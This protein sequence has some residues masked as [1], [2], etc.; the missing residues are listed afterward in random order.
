MLR[1]INKRLFSKI[2]NKFEIG[3]HMIPHPNK[4]ATGGEDAYTV[5]PDKRLIAMADGVGGWAEAGIDSGVFS[6]NLCKNI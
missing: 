5:C 2:A 4:I 1:N 3:A 6:R